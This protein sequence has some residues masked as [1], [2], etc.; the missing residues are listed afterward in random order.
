MISDEEWGEP[1][2]FLAEQTRVIR[3]G[4]AALVTPVLLAALAFGL[5]SMATKGAPE[6]AA[7]GAHPALI[8]QH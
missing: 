1:K 2:L 5:A 6:I 3:R 4:L 8:D 7:S